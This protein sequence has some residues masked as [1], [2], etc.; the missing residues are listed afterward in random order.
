[1]VGLADFPAE[2][3]QPE[4]GQLEALETEGNA[5]DGNAQDQTAKQVGQENQPAAKQK[6]ENI[7]Q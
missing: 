1:M 7:E 3:R 4:D 6:P 5:D 2:R